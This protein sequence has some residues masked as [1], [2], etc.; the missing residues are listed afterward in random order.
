M[1]KT[2]ELASGYAVQM[3]EDDISAL[4]ATQPPNDTVIKAKIADFF[5]RRFTERYIT[6]INAADSKK[7]HGFCTMAVSCLMI[8]VLQC[9]WTGAK[10]TR[11]RGA[12]EK[13]FKHFFKRTP[14]L[15][16]FSNSTF[17]YDIRC[18]ILHQAETNAGWKINRQNENGK[19]KDGFSIDAT[20]FHRFVGDALAKH[21]DL[22]RTEDRTSPVWRHFRQKMVHV[23]ENC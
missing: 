3:Y 10:D 15:S 23:C 22:L 21:A 2:T 17:Y 11:P 12:G 5:V 14:S 19:V 18:G 7:K 8:E 9:F 16:E 1:D 13:A 4:D 6:P 20:M